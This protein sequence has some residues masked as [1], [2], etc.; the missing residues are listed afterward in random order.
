MDLED[1]SKKIAELPDEETQV[2]VITKIQEQDMGAETAKRFITNIKHVNE[3]MRDAYLTPGVKPIIEEEMTPMRIEIP[4][5]EARSLKEAIE[6]ERMEMKERL[7]QPEVKEQ[8]RLMNSWLAHCQ[9]NLDSLT[10]PV[11]GSDYH[12]LIFSICLA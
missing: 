3:D 9:L 6:T 7:K 11:C 2:K 12:N 1:Y 10:C 5:E 4:E 8:A